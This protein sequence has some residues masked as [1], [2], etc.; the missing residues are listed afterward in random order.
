V[1]FDLTLA[2]LSLDGLEENVVVI[3]LKEGT[4]VLP[5]SN[6]HNLRLRFEPF[7]DMLRSDSAVHSG[8]EHLPF[9]V[10]A[11]VKDGE[12]VSNRLL[13]LEFSSGCVA[14]SIEGCKDSRKA[15]PEEKVCE[16]VGVTNSLECMVLV[17]TIASL[18]AECDAEPAYDT[19]LG[20]DP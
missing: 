6:L 10:L 1:N 3:S 4:D 12:F 14:R 18:C 9:C 15:G 8:G 20:R 13:P 7:S 17:P 5:S 11:D 2:G 19:A 16:L